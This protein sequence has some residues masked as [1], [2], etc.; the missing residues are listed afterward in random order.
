MGGSSS[1]NWCNVCH[2]RRDVTMENVWHEHFFHDETE[3]DN[4]PGIKGRYDAIETL[5]GKFLVWGAESEQ[6]VA[7]CTSR[8]HARLTA[9]LIAKRNRS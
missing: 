9:S 8:A 7:Y 2:Y 6:V 3:A 1:V 5:D 4:W